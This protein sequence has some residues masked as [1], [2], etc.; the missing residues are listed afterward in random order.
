MARILVVDDTPLVAQLV[1]L[2]LGRS[3]HEIHT[4]D[5]GADGVAA[6]KALRPDLILMDV[7][8]PELDGYQATQLIRKHPPTALTP[9]I[10]LTAQ[11][12]LTEKMRGFEAG[13]DDYMTKPFEPAELSMR[14]DVHLKRAEALSAALAA[15]T[16]PAQSNGR[17]LA[18]FSLR[19]GSGVSTL[20]VNLAISLTEI[21]SQPAVL[22]D[23]A[24]TG[25][26]A[27]LLLDVPLKRTWANLAAAQPEELEPEFVE[28]HLARH[29]SGVRLLASPARAE[30]GDLVTGPHVT[31]AL[32]LLR[33]SY[34][35]LVADLPHDFRDTTLPALD[36]ADL[37]LM[38]F[39]PDLASLRSAAAALDT[40]K[41]LDYPLDKV[42]L[43]LNHTFAKHALAQADIERALNRKIDFVIPHAADEVV[44]AVNVGQPLALSAATSPAGMVFEDYAYRVSRPEDTDAPPEKPS[45][46]YQRVTRRL[47][48]PPAKKA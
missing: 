29:R 3:G 13:A 9:I 15:Q 12:S 38:P 34:A 26:H 42:R 43:I 27:A 21:W 8:M 7:M 20:A 39:A 28:G 46:A 17:L 33:L 35:Y 24:L 18:C 37:I 48:K 36:A 4:A 22:L 44:K 45:H 47:T 40:F 41:V 11:D 2:A 1:K 25:G 30:D 14:V 16:A 10:I 23:L 19:G 32:R 6:A 31:N 5:N